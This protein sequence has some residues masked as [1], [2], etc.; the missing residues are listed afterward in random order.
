MEVL[1]DIWLQLASV[2]RVFHNRSWYIRDILYENV[3]FVRK[4]GGDGWTFLEFGNTSREWRNT[5]KS[6][7]VTVRYAPPEVCIR[8]RLSSKGCAS[9]QSTGAQ[10]IGSQEQV[11]HQIAKRT[12]HKYQQ[13]AY[14]VQRE[15]QCDQR[16]LYVSPH[17]KLCSL[18][19]HG[20]FYCVI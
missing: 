16:P 1:F 6:D 12:K 9:L 11:Q 5:V 19:W 17:Q 20:I 14:C 2:L 10:R 8:V 7:S 15:Q 3:V 4:G 18:L 13:L